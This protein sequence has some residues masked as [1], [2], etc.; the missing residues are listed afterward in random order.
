M[1]VMKT[2]TETRVEEKWQCVKGPS[3]RC[4]CHFSVSVRLNGWKGRERTIHLDVIAKW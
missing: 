3:V 4:P 1:D 2:I